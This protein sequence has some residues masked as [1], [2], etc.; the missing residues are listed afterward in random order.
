MRQR[1]RDGV[2]LEKVRL[3]KTIKEISEKERRAFENCHAFD[4]Y[5]V[6]REIGV[7]HVHKCASF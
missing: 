4:I 5:H 1:T 3:E 2:R 7:R 6:F